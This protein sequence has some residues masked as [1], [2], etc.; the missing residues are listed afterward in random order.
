M[1]RFKNHPKIA[2]TLFLL[3]SVI[4]IWAMGDFF[5]NMF[6]PLTWLYSIVFIVV[7]LLL[8]VIMRW[9]EKDIQEE[10]ERMRLS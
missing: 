2:S 3:L 7:V 4:G 1:P 9:A 10:R 6:S 8:S 5:N